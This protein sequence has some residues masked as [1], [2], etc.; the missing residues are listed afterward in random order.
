MGYWQGG[1]YDSSRTEVFEAYLDLRNNGTFQL[2][3]IDDGTAFEAAGT[4]TTGPSDSTSGRIDFRVECS[5]FSQF[6]SSSLMRGVFNYSAI[7]YG[8]DEYLGFE[9]T[10][11]PVAVP[12]PGDTDL[13]W[14]F[15]KVFED[16]P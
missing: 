13:A 16:A 7:V 1:A 3:A 15:S 8:I 11:A 12:E 4:W 10:V 5:N 6:P 2:Q 14:S 9:V